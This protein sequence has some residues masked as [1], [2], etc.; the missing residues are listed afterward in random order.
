MVV[1]RYR[2][3]STLKSLVEYSTLRE[4]RKMLNCSFTSL[5]YLCAPLPRF[6]SYSLFL[7]LPPSHSRPY[8]VHIGSD[9]Q[10]QPVNFPVDAISAPDLPRSIRTYCTLS[11]NEVVCAVAISDPVKHIYTGG[12]VVSTLQLAFA[13]VC[14]LCLCLLQGCVKVWDLQMVQSGSRTLKT[15]IHSLDC[16]GDNYIR[17]CKLLPDGRTLIVGGETNTLYMWDL[18]AVRYLINVCNS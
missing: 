18:A 4:N 12:K 1:L 8:S 7:S 5:F 13:N 6:Y 17:S 16:L 2:D 14:S 10:V 11:H 9:G 15:P 3:T